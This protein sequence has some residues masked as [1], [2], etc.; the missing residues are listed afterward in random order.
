MV[1]KEQVIGPLMKVHLMLEAGRS[2]EGNAYTLEPVPFEFIFGI[3]SGGMTPFEYALMEKGEGDAI[4][5][6]VTREEEAVLF[7]HLVLPPLGV[8]WDAHTYWLRG[9]IHQ[10]LQADQREVVAAMA[11]A[12][13]CEDHC[14][15]H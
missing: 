9:R 14:C 7:E 6:Q 10:V 15:G 13:Q 1:D 12:S 4:S 2:K 3:G 8:P 5:L 11:A